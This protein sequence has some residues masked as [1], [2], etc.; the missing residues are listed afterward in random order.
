MT[1]TL[2][3]EE[4]SR[5]LAIYRDCV[6]PL[7]TRQVKLLGRKCQPVLM[8]TFLGLELR[9]GRKRITCPDM[10]T[11][12]YLGVFAELGVKTIQIPYDPTRT[13]LIL[14]ELEESFTNIKQ[15]VEEEVGGERD[16]KRHVRGVFGKIRAGLA[17]S[18]SARL[19]S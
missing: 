3:S 19:D 7:R 1:K 13:G 11:A 8:K 16:P 9:L 2:L 15:A 14:A 4:M 6:L 5:L 12:R 18:E 17:A 10:I